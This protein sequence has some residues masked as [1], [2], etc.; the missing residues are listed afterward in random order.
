MYQYEQMMSAGGEAAQAAPSSR[1]CN[2]RLHQKVAETMCTTD[3]HTKSR[4]A[5]G[6]M[7]EGR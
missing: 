3:S 2:D 6:L 5:H 7:L 1:L 4:E